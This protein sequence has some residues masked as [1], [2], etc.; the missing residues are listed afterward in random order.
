MYKFSLDLPLFGLGLSCKDHGSNLWL[1]SNRIALFH[2]TLDRH[3]KWTWLACYLL[4]FFF[5]NK[6]LECVICC[7]W[8]SC[9]SVFSWGRGTWG[10][11][12]KGVPKN[13]LVLEPALT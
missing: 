13:A 5:R 6:W 7:R 4:F 1:S 2:W 9:R 10:C 12:P 11:E 8:G 3:L